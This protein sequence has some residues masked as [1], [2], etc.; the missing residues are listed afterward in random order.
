MVGLVTGIVL[1]RAPDLLQV[2]PTPAFFVPLM[3]GLVVDLL[4]RARSQDGGMGLI[5]MP[6]RGAGVI[7][8][9]LIAAGASA[10]LAP[11]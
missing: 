1:A 9:A 11:A 4:V 3:A 7:G 5:S 6:E 10:L 8:G 2:L